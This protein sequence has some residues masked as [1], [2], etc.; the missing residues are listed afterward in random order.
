MANDYC[1]STTE[2]RKRQL[3]GMLYALKAVKRGDFTLSSGAKSE[4]YFDARVAALD[5][6][7]LSIICPLMGQ[8]ISEYSFDSIGCMEGP[9]SVSILGALLIG[10]G[11]QRTN[12]PISGFVVRKKAKE[13]GTGKIVE[14]HI[15]KS[16]ILID[17]VA[18]SG[19]ALLHAVNNMGVSPLAAIVMLDRGQGAGEALAS[20]N[21]PVRAVLTMK[22]LTL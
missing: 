10:Y 6:E 1:D 5:P 9:G 14:G 15:G 20:R 16:P 18:T 4:Y 8:M 12:K 17:D 21:V 2:Y 19:K 22:D 3:V 7:A 11:I 13:H